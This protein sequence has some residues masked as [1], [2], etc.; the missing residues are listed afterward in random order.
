MKTT[1][2]NL[3][4]AAPLLAVPASAQ[5][6]PA[7]KEAHYSKA[8]P[9]STPLFS[10][11]ISYGNLVFVLG[12][13]VNDVSGIKAQT[14]KVL[15]DIETSLKAAGT[16]LKNALKCNVYLARLEDYSA[17]NEVYLGRFGNEPPVRTTLAVAGIPLA[18]CL[19]E[20]E[21]IAFR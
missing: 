7:F 16:S 3:L 13:G 9:T 18:G 15:D 8:K 19:V 2:R 5:T 10:E 1:R 4:T 21:V 12:H 11:A 14:T 17:M 20:I 6:R